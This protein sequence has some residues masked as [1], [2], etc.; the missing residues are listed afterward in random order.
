MAADEDEDEENYR[1]TDELALEADRTI[2]AG[3]P[4]LLLFPTTQAQ[5]DEAIARCRGEWLFLAVLAA[6]LVFAVDW[7]K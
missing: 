5:R 7:R 6:V 3:G 1:T 4:R 2:D